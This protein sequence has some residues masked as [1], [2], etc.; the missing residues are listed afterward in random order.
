MFVCASS[1]LTYITN[2]I[3]AMGFP[4][5]GSEAIYRNDMKDVQQ[6]LNTRHKDHYKVYNLCSERK[7]Q[8]EKFGGRVLEFPYEHNEAATGQAQAL[9]RSCV[10]ELTRSPFCFVPLSNA[11]IR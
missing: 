2:R 8:H 4:A 1:D 10:A 9:A 11:Q 7:Y 5:D 6:F 3:I